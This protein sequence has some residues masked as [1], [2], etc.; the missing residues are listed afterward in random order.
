LSWNKFR[1]KG[2]K[3]LAVGIKVHGLVSLTLESV[4][5]QGE[6]TKKINSN[7]A[8]KRKTSD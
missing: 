6:T 8:K 1:K 5:P 2:A 3:E 4:W 7:Y